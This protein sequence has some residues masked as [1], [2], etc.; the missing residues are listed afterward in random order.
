MILS[1]SLLFVTAC[2]LPYNVSCTCNGRKETIRALANLNSY[3]RCSFSSYL[4]V[5][6]TRAL[7]WGIVAYAIAQPVILFQS[8][9]DNFWDTLILQDI[10]IKVR[11]FDIQ[12]DLADASA[13]SFS[14]YVG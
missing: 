4:P 8:A 5:V 1:N 10:I 7:I 2:L 3:M 12:G 13:T 11:M 6:D 9:S 14:H